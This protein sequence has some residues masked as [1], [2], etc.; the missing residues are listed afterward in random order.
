MMNP[1]KI[2]L[3]NLKDTISDTIFPLQ[4]KYLDLTSKIM[5]LF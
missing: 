3:K 1:K 5:K 2:L 4:K